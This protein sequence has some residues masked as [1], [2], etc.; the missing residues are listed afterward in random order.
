MGGEKKR[1]GVGVFALGEVLVRRSSRGDG[2]LWGWAND[3]GELT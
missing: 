1:V 3:L 2:A